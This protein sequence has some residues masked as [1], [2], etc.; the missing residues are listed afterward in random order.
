MQRQN[1]LSIR[2]SLFTSAA[3]CA[4]LLL[5]GCKDTDELTVSTQRAEQGEVIR[6]GG[7]STEGVVAHASTTRAGDGDAIDEETVVRT[8]AENIEWLRTP[9][10]YGLD[11]TYGDYDNRDGTSRVAV[12][13]LKHGSGPNG[14]E[15]STFTEK[16]VEKN[17]AAYTFNYRDNTTGEETANPALWHDNGSHFF[18]GVHVPAKIANNAT[19]TLPA[20]LATDQHLDGDAGNYTQLSR[21]LAMP[22]DFRL[23]ATVGRIKL[24]FRHRLGRVLAYILIDPAMNGATL[25]GYDYRAATPAIP[26]TDSS[27]AVEATEERPD[28]PTTTSLRFCNVMVLSGVDDEVTELHH[29]YTPRW[30]VARKVV[31]HFV[32]ERGSYDD[33]KNQYVTGY[34][35]HFVAF[36]NK[37][38]KTYVY[39]TDAE[40]TTIN[41]TFASDAPETG[42]TIEKGEWQRL[43]YGKVPVYDIIVQPTYKYASRVMYDE[44]MT[45]TNNTANKWAALENKIDFELTLS[46]GLNYEKEFLF[47]LDANDQTVVYLHI[48]HEQVDYSSSGSMVWQETSGYDD[49]YGVNN[50]NGH[51]LSI[52]GSSWQRAYTYNPDGLGSV[53]SPFTD[54]VTDGHYYISDDEDEYAQY[55]SQGKFIEMLREAHAGGK[56]HGDYFILRSDIT[57]PAAAFPEGF[58]FTG[59]LDGQDHTITITNTS[60]IK[61]TRHPSYVTYENNASHTEAKYVHVSGDT[62]SE[63]EAGTYT[64]YQRTVTKDAENN[65]VVTYSVIPDIYAF[66]GSTAYIYS[67]IDEYNDPISNADNNYTAYQFYKRVY[68]DENNT[69]ETF[70]AKTGSYYLFAGLNGKYSTAQENA[71]NPYTADW[72]ANVH[73]EGSYWVPRKTTTDGWRAEIINTN[74]DISS[75]TG[76]SV[77][78]TG[79][80]YA[81]EADE[82]HP[83]DITG[84]LHNCWVN[85]SYNATTKKWTGGDKIKEYT[86]S[87]PEY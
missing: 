64:Y 30:T 32:G 38:K 27:P 31:P 78:K 28:E 45:G 71:D 19:N 16:G 63:F 67:G 34:E 57:I 54:N 82:D 4:V 77:F 2:Y 87:I 69:T 76:C 22:A 86:P 11:I 46:N 25:K 72:E 24:P 70:P 40:W 6:V 3:I 39:P 80:R 43:V 53:P 58:V 52:A 7:I 48:S 74:F 33:S 79:V 14:I 1:I 17:L 18:E 26:A 84:Y 8:D 21:Y 44:D 61:T 73:K 81:D 42:V 49:W 36:Y 20:D 23:S 41:A 51:T 35:D 59:H 66:D 68:C 83:A 56:H 13:K 29:K 10:F 5:T 85:S 75:A 60:Y 15:Y 9:L 12:L 62:Y 65:D 55:V 50:G 37:T 47:D